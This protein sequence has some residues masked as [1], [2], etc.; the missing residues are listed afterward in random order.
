MPFRAVLDGKNIYSFTFSH[1]EWNI[2]KSDKKRSGLT[3]ACCPERA[4]VKSSPLGTQYF[5]HY[6]KS[7]SC[8]TKPESKEHLFLKDKIARAA[9]S[10][11]WDVQSEFPGSTPSGEQWQA[12]VFCTKGKLKIALEIQL[13]PQSQA[14]FSRRQKKY[15]DSLVRCAWFIGGRHYK[16]TK[17]VS[18]KPVPVFFVEDPLVVEYP[19]IRSFETHISNFVKHLLSGKITWVD[20][21]SEE[22]VS[23]LESRCWKCTKPMKQPYGF[24]FDV[25]DY[26]IQTVPHCSKILHEIELSF[27]NTFLRDNGICVIESHQNMKGNAPHA[28][29]CTVCLYCGTPQANCYLLQNYNKYLRDESTGGGMVTK[30]M[31]RQNGRWQIK[32]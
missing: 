9:L 23:Y 19:K 1:E 4:I 11:G 22:Y 27:G 3:M 30:I 24:G 28:P 25:F 16:K 21:P 26:G 29:F 18:T 12:D 8:T 10:A 5:A 13:S 7:E 17:P 31:G 14:E 6:K 32:P 2:F 15:K 20:E